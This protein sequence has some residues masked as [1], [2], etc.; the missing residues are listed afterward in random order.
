MQDFNK[1][2]KQLYELTKTRAVS[3]TF[4][5]ERPVGFFHNLSPQPSACSFWKLAAEGR[6]FYADAPDH[7]S[8]VLGAY[9]LDAELSAIQGEELAGLASTMV[10]LSYLKADE[11]AQLPRCSQ[12]LRFVTYAPLS[13]SSVLPDIALV[14]GNAR[15]LMLLTEAA[16]AV[17]LFRDSATM[18]RPACAM[19]PECLSSGKVVL[20]LGCTGNR[21]FTGLQDHEGYLAI[22]GN[23]I[24]SVCNSLVTLLRANEVLSQLHLEKHRQSAAI[25]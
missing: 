12:P 22:P 4:S 11:L 10:K 1:W 24:E 25:Q 5:A 21:V 17:G 20:S 7:T 18:G 13:L 14:R 9:I 15:H 6:R 16:R 8:C 23:A 3:I 19:V 2:D